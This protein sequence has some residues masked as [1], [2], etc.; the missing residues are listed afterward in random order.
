M[1][2]GSLIVMLTKMK[3]YGFSGFCEVV[4]IMIRG[5]CAVV[6]VLGTAIVVSWC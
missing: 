3:Q 2:L 5:F 6:M 4:V 1:Q